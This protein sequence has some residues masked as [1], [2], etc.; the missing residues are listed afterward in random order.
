MKITK[1]IIPVAGWG[2]RRLPVTKAIEKC[3]L[4]IGNR[5]IID[6]IVQDCLLAGVTDIYFVVNKAGTQLEAYY[7]RDTR[8]ES[9]LKA[10]GKE[11]FI[12]A[13]TPPKATF[14]FVVQDTA[15]TQKYGTAIPVAL[16]EP[17]MNAD[18]SIAVVMGDDFIYS[19]AGESELARLI[20]AT[21]SGASA[22]LGVTVP[23]KEVSRYGV[24]ALDEQS[25][26]LQIVEKP[27]IED[28]PSN[29]INPSRYIISAQ[30]RQQIVKY[31]QAEKAGE[32]Y[33]TDPINDYVA[34]G[35]VM[36]VVKAQGQYLD[37]GTVVGWLAANNFVNQYE[38]W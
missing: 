34:A 15:T 14:H 26:F 2:T 20:A 32:Y 24:I 10:N 5:P 13:V 25:N 11:A 4:P 35:G 33:I 12:A 19:P 9:Y 18:E 8:L 21:P 27:A 23:A 38:R 36:K 7:N 3:M 31:T 22:M 37:G 30:L 1:A 16:C 17:H 6:Y 28:A 29:L